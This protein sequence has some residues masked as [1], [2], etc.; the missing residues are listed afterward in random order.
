MSLI[1]WYAYL[2]SCAVK[3]RLLNIKRPIM[4][5]VKITHECNLKCLHCPFWGRKG[6]G[7]SFSKVKEAFN[8]LHKL[9]VRIVIIEG[10]EPFLWKDGSY[11]IKDV[12]KEA[13]RLFFCVGIT[14]NG[15]FPLS[16]EPDV[17]WVSIDGLEEMHDSIRGKYFEKIMANLRDCPHTR[18]YAHVT[19][20][21]L[22]WEQI[23]GL[24]EFLFSKVKG[25]TVQFYYPYEGGED[26]LFLPFSKRRIVLDNLIRMKSNGFSVANSY[27]CLEAMKDNSWKCHS[28]MI[29][30]VGPE[31]KI[32]KGCYVKDKGEVSCGKCGFS[33][34]TEISLAYSGSM[35]AILTGNRLL[36]PD[37]RG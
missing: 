6:K 16:A 33:A 30:S 18:V 37:R 27:A 13:K 5:G 32:T 4:A 3:S 35:E 22:N 15:T 7:L 28:W 26:R 9:G 19:I 17:F 1:N 29:A 23:P 12:V 20:N 10:G 8:N 34:H 21:S 25:I 2:F 36:G 31:G 14:T 11:T 24:V